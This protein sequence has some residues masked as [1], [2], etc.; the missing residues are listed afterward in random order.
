M[1]TLAATSRA[2][3]R[4][5]WAGAPLHAAAYGRSPANPRTALKRLSAQPAGAEVAPAP[6]PSL[7]TAGQPPA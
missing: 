4:I 7:A 6:A 2:P 3:A 5:S 1:D